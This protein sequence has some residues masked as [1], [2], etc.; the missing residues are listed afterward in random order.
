MPGSSGFGEYSDLDHA[1]DLQRE[2]DRLN[3]ALIHIARIGCAGGAC[4]HS[5]DVAKEMRAVAIKA[6]GAEAISS[7]LAEAEGK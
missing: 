7:F 5:V 1:S 3:E 4:A 2:V 6:V